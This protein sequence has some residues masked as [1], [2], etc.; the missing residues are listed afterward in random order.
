MIVDVLGFLVEPSDGMM[1]LYRLHVRICMHVCPSTSLL[2]IGIPKIIW[3]GGEPSC[4]SKTIFQEIEVLPAQVAGDG[5]IL[6]KVETYL[7]HTLL[8]PA[9]RVA[10]YL[11]PAV[12]F[13]TY[14]IGLSR[15]N[16]WS[17]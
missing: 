11:E 9:R 7:I 8:V 10:T 2:L 17:C 4:G 3:M 6:L 15:R 14:R 16:E 13:G 12:R 1:L 5:S